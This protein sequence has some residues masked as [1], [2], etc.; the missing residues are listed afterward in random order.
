MSELSVSMQDGFAGAF[1]PKR[2]VRT[3]KILLLQGL[4]GRLFRRLGQG[5]TAAGHTVYKVNFNGGDRIFWRLSNG[6]DYC[7][8]LDEWP[9]TL[10]DLIC[11]LEITDVALFGDCRD[12]H[13]PAVKVCK[14]LGIPVHVFEEGYIRPNWVTLEAGGVNGNSSLPKNPD[15]YRKAAAKL[16]D[17]PDHG[18]V[19]SIFRRRAVEALIYNTA[20]I[21]TRWHYPHWRNHRPWHPLVEFVGWLQKLNRRKDDEANSRAL[22]RRSADQQYFLFPLQLDSDAQILLHSPF[23]GIGGALKSVV[24][25]FARNAPPNVRLMVKEHPLD[26]GV[27]NWRQATADL[28]LLYGVEDRVDYLARGSINQVTKNALGVVTINS[29]SGSLALSM[30]V[31]V[32]TLGKAIYDI[33][34]ITFQ[35]GLDAFW[36]NPQPPD[37]A[38]Y[39]AFVRILQDRCLIPGGYFSER[40]LELVVEHAIARFE[41]R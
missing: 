15:F 21:L 26:N 13:V 41:N 6:I 11:R 18:H 2:S 9:D 23:A 40:G 27:K 25:S 35:G 29:T 22:M 12:Y 32:V 30:G 14:Q 19:P 38:T 28:A 20:D 17:V 31:P 16:P 33:A 1:A 4:M 10:K 7:G 37:F 36:S 39:S 24:E 5:L 8:T 34:D 3:R